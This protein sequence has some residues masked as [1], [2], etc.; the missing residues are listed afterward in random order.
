MKK[1][2][3]CRALLTASILFVTKD[4]TLEPEI[5]KCFR[6][7]LKIASSVLDIALQLQ[8]YVEILSHLTLYVRYKNE[9]IDEIICSLIKQIN[10]KNNDTPLSE[11]ANKQFQN[12][13]VFFRKSGM[14]IGAE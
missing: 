11:L 8:L 4:G 14:N 1:S 5:L 12:S 7:C 6:K 10:E 3:Q 13:L 9:D 2:D